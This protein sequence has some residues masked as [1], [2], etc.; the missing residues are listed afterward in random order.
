MDHVV[1]YKGV[2]IS[3]NL[4]AKNSAKDRKCALRVYFCAFKEMKIKT[5]TLADH[6]FFL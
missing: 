6:Y 2:S 5:A 3:N 4:V 1:I